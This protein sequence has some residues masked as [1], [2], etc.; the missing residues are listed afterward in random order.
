MFRSLITVAGY[1]QCLVIA[2][3]IFLLPARAAQAVS[4]TVMN[5]ATHT[6]NSAIPVGEQVVTFGIQVTEADLVG[7]GTNPVLLVQNLAF[8]GNGIVPINATGLANKVDVQDVQT[9]VVDPYAAGNSA[10]A[11][12]SNMSATN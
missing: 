3:M 1:W 10:P 12:Q 11:Q 5:V 6:T 4:L 9:S 8:V 2:M 7:A